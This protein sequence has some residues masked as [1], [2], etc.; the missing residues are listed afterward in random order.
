M[1]L[2]HDFFSAWYFFYR[3]L[4]VAV[5]FESSR[6]TMLQ[7][8]EI[9]RR[10]VKQ[11]ENDVKLRRIHHL[12]VVRINQLIYQQRSSKKSSIDSPCSSGELWTHFLWLHGILFSGTDVDSFHPVP[13]LDILIQFILPEQ[14]ITVDRALKCA[15]S[16]IAAC[17][18]LR[19]RY[20]HLVLEDNI[21]FLCALQ[22]LF[23]I[24]HVLL[25][26]VGLE[27]PSV[28]VY[29]LWL[30]EWI[31]TNRALIA[32]VLQNS[33]CKAV[34]F[35]IAE[36]LKQATTSI[37]SSQNNDTKSQI[38]DDWLAIGI[39]SLSVATDGQDLPVDINGDII[40]TLQLLLEFERYGTKPNAGLIWVSRIHRWNSCTT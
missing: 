28:S 4:C 23:S 8:I 26:A 16:G 11:L 30:F 12:P 13:F 21:A 34:S 18:W 6:E 9:N 17:Q 2:H 35:C 32:Q 36:F 20:S 40:P 19:D 39:T 1:Q 31:Y 7:L 15:L 10:E 14:Q 37:V 22:C 33:R 24:G 38:V 29:S 5:P 3:S 27:Q 25:A